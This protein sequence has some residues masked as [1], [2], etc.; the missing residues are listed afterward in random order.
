RGAKNIDHVDRLRDIS[1]PGVDFLIEQLASSEAGIDRD[2]VVAALEKIFKREITRPAGIGRDPHHGDGFHGIENAANVAI[3]IIVVVH[4]GVQRSCHLGG[5]FSIKAEMP[6]PASR[7]IMFFTMTC[8]VYSYAS[9][10]PIS[11]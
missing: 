1:E 6:S 3:G 11:S 2:H 10:T 4:A 5:R 8:E 7:A 9:A